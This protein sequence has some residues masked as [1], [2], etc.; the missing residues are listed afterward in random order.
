M[1]TELDT[2]QDR[3]DPPLRWGFVGTGA[4]AGRMAATLATTHN[5]TLSAVTS[6]RLERRTRLERSRTAT[7]FLSTAGLC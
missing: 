3:T 5:A 1:Q 4:I 2:R 7:S 6:R